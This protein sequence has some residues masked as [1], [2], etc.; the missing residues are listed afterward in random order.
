MPLSLSMLTKLT[1]CATT[2]LARPSSALFVKA[3]STTQIPGV[4]VSP[5]QS[6]NNNN[7]YLRHLPSS[8]LSLVLPSTKS[9]SYSKSF[10]RNMSSSPT[11]ETAKK[12]VLV[13]IA[14]DS[15]EIETTCITDVLARFGAE[16]VVASVQPDGNLVCKMSRGVKIMADVTIEEAAKEEW[17]LIALPGG[18]PGANHLRDCTTLIE[19]LKKQQEKK[20]LYGAMCASP[21]VV[22][23]THNL[24]GSGATCY[25]APQ[26]RSVMADASDEKVVVQDNVVTSQGP[27][28]SL[29]FA[30]AMGEQLYGKEEADGIAKALLVER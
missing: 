30:L 12:R 28:T 21:A 25:P 6:N 19:L 15:E 14:E 27:G 24:V 23:A 4:T 1:I 5:F 26:F 11:E 17:D 22:F 18:L 16:V 3:F 9:S 20:K 8:P 2:L 10:I 29:L 7:N 13:P